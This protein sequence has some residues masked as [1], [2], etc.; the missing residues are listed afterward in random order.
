MKNPA[1][2]KEYAAKF[3]AECRANK[4][5]TSLYMTWAKQDAVSRQRE[6]TA[7]YEDAARDINALVVP[8][9][10]AWQKAMQMQ[11]ELVLYDRDKSH[12]S[13]AGTYL[14]ACVFYG[15]LFGKTPVGLPSEGIS[16]TDAA[17]IQEAAWKV[18]SG[19]NECRSTE[20]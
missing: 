1:R 16:A 15:K 13:M 2:L 6:I 7:A 5:L 20:R 8:V 17:T 12:P 19:G 4:A 11:R 9:G 10:V 18:C 3:D 14:A